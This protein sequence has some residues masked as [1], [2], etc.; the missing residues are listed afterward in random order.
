MQVGKSKGVAPAGSRV[1]LIDQTVVDCN[2]VLNS[3]NWQAALPPLSLPLHPR[4]S[5]LMKTVDR[6][7]IDM[8]NLICAERHSI[9]VD[10][11]V[12]LSKWDQMFDA[13][14]PHYL[15]LCCVQHRITRPDRV[16]AAKWVRWGGGEGRGSLM[17]EG[18]KS[19]VNGI[20]K[21]NPF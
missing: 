6:R 15:F 17:G 21:S 18:G 12:G 3:I 11:F 13:F 14:S 16:I 2:F 20:V 7:T 5:S 4:C 9:L 10:A 1:Y 8:V 19:I